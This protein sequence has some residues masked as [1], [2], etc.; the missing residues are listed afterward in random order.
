MT[1]MLLLATLVQE[2]DKKMPSPSSNNANNNANNNKK[3][4]KLLRAFV[5]VWSKQ[6]VQS[7]TS[8]LFLALL[9]TVKIYNLH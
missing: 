6:Q 5:L 2:C 3:A 1:R 7:V 9:C 4:K 8:C